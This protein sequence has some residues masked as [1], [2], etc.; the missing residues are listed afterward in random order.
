MRNDFNLMKELASHTHIEPTPR[1]QSLMDMVNTIN[2]APRCRQYM[3]K[4][5]LRLD[6]NLVELEARTLEPETINYS[7][8]SV[9]YKQ[10]EADW[11]RDG[12]SC[13]HLKP[14]HL[15]KW[16]V[17]YEGKQKPIANELINTLYNVCTPMGM[18]VEYPE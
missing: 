17:V 8:R 2:T 1:Y 7:D 6:D 4:W 16:L 15:D 11:S 3:S 12:R 13:R 5:N 10:Q 9:R 14:G 18:R